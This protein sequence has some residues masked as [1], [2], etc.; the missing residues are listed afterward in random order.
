MCEPVRLCVC[1]CVCECVCVCVCVR[2]CVCQETLA[3]LL[4]ERTAWP[5]CVPLS[6][7]LVTDSKTGDSE[8]VCVCVSEYVSMFVCMCDFLWGE[9]GH[10]EIIWNMVG[11]QNVI[12]FQS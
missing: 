4:L 6:R 2:V 1:M 8:A 9:R 12:R 5:S 11:E 3:F 10:G 7:T